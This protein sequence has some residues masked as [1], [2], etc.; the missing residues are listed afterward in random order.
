MSKKT[1]E[2][3]TNLVIDTLGKKKQALIFVNSKKRAE[4]TA[5]DISKSLTTKSKELDEISEKLKKALDRPTKQCLRL[6]ACAKKGVVFHH[7]GLVSKQR[8]LIEDS[9]RSSLIK[10]ICCTPTLCISRN[11]KIWH[12]MSETEISKFKN[13]NPLFVLS[14]NKLISMKAQKIQ[15]IK[16]SSKL[17][18][19]SSVSGYSIKVT[20]HHRMLIKRNNRKM[21]LQAKNIKKSDKIATMGRLNISK[22]VIPS[23]KEFIIENKTDIFNYKF[24]PKLSYFIGVILGDGYSG[25]EINNEKIKYKGSPSIVG[26]DKEIFLHVAKVCSKFNLNCRKT[27]TFHGTPQLVLGKNKW[28][29][30][31][32]VRCGVEQRDKKQI[33]EILMSMNLENISYLLRGLFDTDGWIEKQEGVGFSNVSEKLVKQIQKQLLRFGIVSAIRKRKRSSMKIY[34][35]EYKTGPQFELAIRQKRSVIDF[36]RYIGFGVKRKQDD[37]INRIA[38]ICSNLNYVSCNHCKYKIYRDVFSGRAKKHK[39]WGLIKLKVIKLLG[40]KGELGSRELKKILNHE[41]RKK[42]R[43]VNHHY[44]LIKK[45]RIGNRDDTEW[46]WSLNA[47][48]EWI[49]NNLIDKNKKIEEFFSLRECPLCRNQLD[50]II[51]KGWRDSDFDN[52]LFWDKIREIKNAECEEDVYDIILPNRHENDH[53]FVANGFIVHNSLGV[54]LP[55]FRTIIKDLKRYGIHGLSW[56]PVMEYHQMAGRAGR[57]GK[58]KFGEAIIEVSTD[59]EQEKVLERYIKG[60]PEPIL[61]KLAVEPVLRTYILSLIATEFVRNEKQIFDFFSRTFWAFQFEDMKEIKKIILKM[62]KLL[63]ENNFIKTN[64]QDDFVSA[65]EL[66]KQD[67]KE[68][69]ATFLGKRVAE[70][71]IDPL[72]AVEIVNTFE[73][74]MK[75]EHSDITFLYMICKCLELRPLLRVRISD[76][77]KIQE[78]LAVYEEHILDEI[79]EFSE[80][81]DLYIDS[82][83]TALMLKDWIEEK[84]EEYIL[85]KYNI[86]PGELNIK[87]TNS[88]W[89][90]YSAEEIGKIIKAKKVLSEIKKLRIRMKYGVKQELLTLLKL[91]KIGR[92]RARKLYNAGLRNIGKIRKANI[93]TLAQII[94]KNLAIDVK[95]QLGEKIGEINIKKT[96]QQNIS[97]Y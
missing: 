97:D 70:L 55:A 91:K 68:I 6:A 10:I 20:P 71:Y 44:E 15:K 5:E 3:T 7:A 36:Y 52:D 95:K 45:R 2:P 61:S 23:I 28:F 77:D 16:N 8:T 72:S 11:T 41:P 92:V 84:D 17:I 31:F 33:S 79:T 32:L 88:D 18:Q 49:F 73:K 80:D 35:K 43:R 96:G 66:N 78:K 50:W 59:N 22:I 93:S 38:K 42:E 47:I 37:L 14:K 69:I 81:Y 34:D 87:V 29:R 24:G 60:R 86:R 54:D 94:G 51:K 83:K 53:M 62:L 1:N 39:K 48:G 85:E 26:I 13:S 90:L 40:E 67:K 82:F 74:S 58:E 76:F 46:Y 19:I 56:I 63:E 21:I 27:K 9:F 64:K 12:D 75:K 4:K 57:P 89:L 25:T 30:E 65:S